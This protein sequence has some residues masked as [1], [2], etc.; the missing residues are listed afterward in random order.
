MVTRTRLNIALLESSLQ[1]WTTCIYIIG[2]FSQ[3]KIMF[4]Q[5]WRSVVWYMN[6][7]V[8]EESSSMFKVEECRLDGFY[9][10]DFTIFICGAE[11][12]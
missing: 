5:I 2:K 4:S 10:P 7:K 3:T 1:K 6:T 11:E 9:L 12:E 8:T